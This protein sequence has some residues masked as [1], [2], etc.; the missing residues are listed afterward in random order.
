MANV[1]SDDFAARLLRSAQQAAAIRAGEMEPARS[2]RRKVTARK[3]TAKAA[4][5]FDSGRIR[6]LRE[7]FGVSQPVFAGM[8]GVKPVTLKAWEQG[9]NVPSGS[10]R[11]VLQMMELSPETAIEVAAVDGIEVTR[12]T[13]A[14]R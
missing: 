13:E 3:T 5:P 4:P 9:V 8:I 6:Q 14:Q 1:T 2:S 12:D 11:R 10:A 7:R